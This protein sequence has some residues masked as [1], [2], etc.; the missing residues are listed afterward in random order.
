MIQFIAM[1]ANS[2]VLSVKVVETLIANHVWLDIIYKIRFARN[3]IKDV[4]LVLDSK[5][6]ANP[7]L[8]VIIRLKIN[9]LNVQ[10]AVKPAL[11][12]LIV[13]IA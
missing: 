7:V 13:L 6:I 2:P 3:V 9:V 11:V 1:V 5:I 10:Q 8:M 4:R 12:P